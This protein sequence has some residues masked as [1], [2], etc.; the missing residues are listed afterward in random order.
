MNRQPL[1]QR[2][3]DQQ[4]NSPVSQR[5]AIEGNHEVLGRREGSG[6]QKNGLVQR[7]DDT[8]Y[9]TTDSGTRPLTKHAHNQQPSLS[10]QLEKSVW[11]LTNSLL[12]PRFI[13]ATDQ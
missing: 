13:G 4:L 6:R 3:G 9:V 5:T 2:A 8:F 11:Q 7:P 1:E 10:L 12:G